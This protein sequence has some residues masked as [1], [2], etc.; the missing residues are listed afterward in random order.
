MSDREFYEKIIVRIDAGA[1]YTR[2]GASE[3]LGLSSDT[4]ARLVRWNSMFIAKGAS[5]KIGRAIV[6]NGYDLL[7][8]FRRLQ[9]HREGARLLLDYHD[10]SDAAFAKKYGGKQKTEVFAPGTYLYENGGWMPE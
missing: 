5:R 4:F 2:R 1:E 3:A 7:A 9:D 6:Y 10:L 8:H